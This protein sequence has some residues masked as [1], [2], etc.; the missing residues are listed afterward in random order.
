MN[1]CKQVSHAFFVNKQIIFVEC[2]ISEL[3]QQI[4]DKIK[5]DPNDITSLTILG[6]IQL[7]YNQDF[8]SSLATIKKGLQVDQFNIDLRLDLLE[9]LIQYKKGVFKDILSL[10]EECY[11]LDP[12]YWRCDYLKSYF[13]ILINNNKLHRYSLE[14]AL[15]KQP[16][17]LWVK[18][19]LAQCFAEIN[20]LKS[21]A[22]EY[23]EDMELDIQKSQFN[24]D[25][26]SQQYVFN[27]YNFELLRKMAITNYLLNKQQKAQEYFQMALQ[28]N[29]KSYKIL[30]NIAQFERLHNKDYHKS[31]EYCKQAL[32]YQHDCYLSLFNCAVSYEKLGEEEKF[33]EI[34]KQSLKQKK[35]KQSYHQIAYYFWKKGNMDVTAYYSKKLIERDTTYIYSYYLYIQSQVNCLIDYEEFQDILLQ[36]FNIIQTS[37]DINRSLLQYICN[38]TLFIYQ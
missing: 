13:A 16:N 9:I 18:I 24:V 19:S 35:S 33:I 11:T 4:Q 8:Q 27:N 29:P 15:Q 17:N 28:N 5:K 32:K 21:K 1:L 14:R 3:E 30:A 2:S 38:Q 12:N 22:Q 36:Y 31:I 23:L 34:I 10:F 25:Q 6:Q 37:Q 7:Q 20:S 26:Q